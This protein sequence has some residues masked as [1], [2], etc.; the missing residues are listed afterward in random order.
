MNIY[1]ILND[2][3]KKDYESLISNEA[4]RIFLQLFFLRDFK[5]FVYLLGYRDLGK[6]HNKE[7]EDLSKHRFLTD[8][9]VRN[10][11][12][13]SRGFFKTSLITEAHSIW[14]IVNNPNIRILLVSFTLD[15]AKKPLSA[16]RSV[17]ISNEDFRYFFREFCPV[18]NKD[19]K[20]EFGT[21]ESFTIPNRTKSR[22]EP[23]IMCAGVGTNITGLHFDWMKIDDLVNKDSVTN[24]EQIQS[25][26]DYYSLLRPIFDNPTIPRE[27]VIGTIYH[28][29]DLHC[30]LRENKDFKQ[31]FIPALKDGEF[32]F[33]ERLGGDGWNKLCSDPNMNPYDIQRQWL[34]RPIDP[35][36]AKFKESWWKTYT[37]LPKGTVSYILV[38]P[39]STQKKKSDY[40]VI[41]RWDSDSEGN[42]YLADGIRDKLTVFQRMDAII[43]M[44]KRCN[45]VVG[46]KYEVCGGRH[47]DL[48][49]LKERLLKENLPIMFDETKGT[50]SPKADRIEQRLVGRFY[51]GMFNF[52]QSI[53]FK[54][55]FDGKTYDFVQ[56]YRL[57]YLQFPYNEHDDILDAHSFLFDDPTMLMK[58]EKQKIVDKNKKWTA[59]DW[60]KFYSK[61]EKEKSHGF[62]A[63]EAMRNIHSKRVSRFITQMR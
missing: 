15:V 6:F 5:S 16:I 4:K 1:E 43:M 24:D 44:C 17:F 18:A 9:P 29:N 49:T 7:I 53:I 27:D 13:W 10:L 36:D 22:K 35:K 48:E 54:S 40:T 60:D 23:T 50:N 2:Q 28:F 42:F 26:K 8:N 46:G 55:L 37:E 52:P 56:Q 38:D 32:T 61:I 57:E 45:R 25:S 11:W 62:T 20:I 58:G 33:P 47:G 34:L 41:E 30:S 63:N 19:G 39:A 31:S 3:E 14:L 51:N 59:D 12:L 21:T